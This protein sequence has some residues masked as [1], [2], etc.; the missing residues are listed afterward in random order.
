MSQS[1]EMQR[2]TACVPFQNSKE[3]AINKPILIKSVKHTQFSSLT[4]S[5]L[6]PGREQVEIQERAETWKGGKAYGN[7]RV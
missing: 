2:E 4:L 1:K 5:I 7:Q 6:L 3:Q